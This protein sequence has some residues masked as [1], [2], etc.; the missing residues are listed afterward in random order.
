MSQTILLEFTSLLKVV[1]E[2]KYYTGLTGM[3]DICSKVCVSGRS[4]HLG[5]L[6]S[7]EF[8]TMLD[9]LE[10]CP[11]KYTKI[12]NNINLIFNDCVINHTLPA[13]VR[14]TTILITSKEVSFSDL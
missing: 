12:T 5:S 2:F 11:T 7:G 6:H 14:C 3:N 1:C 4:A 13:I 8:I 10:W 9:F